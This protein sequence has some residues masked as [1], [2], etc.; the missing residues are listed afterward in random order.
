MGIE[1][2]SGH[3]F[4]I[5]MVDVPICGPLIVGDNRYAIWVLGSDQAVAI[6]QYNKKICDILV[7]M[8]NSHGQKHVNVEEILDRLGL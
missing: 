1:A 2:K 3:R 7:M 5:A 6:S 4:R 8:L